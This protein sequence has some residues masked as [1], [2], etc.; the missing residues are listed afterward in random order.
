MSF[1]PYTTTT[2]ISYKSASKYPNC[3][4]D[5]PIPPSQDCYLITKMKNKN[6]ELLKLLLTI[7]HLLSCWSLLIAPKLFCL[8][9]FNGSPAR[10]Q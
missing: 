9:P 5:E 3:R 1:S 8:I 7:L 10:I 4:E 2:Q 6:G